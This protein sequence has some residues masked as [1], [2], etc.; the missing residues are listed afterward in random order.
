[1]FRPIHKNKKSLANR[2]RRTEVNF[3]PWIECNHSIIKL[4]TFFCFFF[5]SLSDTAAIW[6]ICLENSRAK[7]SVIA[8]SSYLET[9]TFWS[10]LS[11]LPD[12]SMSR[13]DSNLPYN[14]RGEYR[15]NILDSNQNTKNVFLY[16]KRYRCMPLIIYSRKHGNKNYFKQNVNL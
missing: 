10:A 13:Y 3:T 8:T 1:M 15:L 16:I 5:R 12:F 14:K 6:K 11:S 7:S 9:A 2:K 4:V